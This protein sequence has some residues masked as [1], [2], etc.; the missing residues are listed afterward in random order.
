LP[1][2]IYGRYDDM[3]VIRGENVY[4]SAIEDVLRKVE[5]FGGEFQIIVSRTDHMDELLVQAEH[6]PTHSDGKSIEQLKI[7]MTEQL[8][9]RLGIR[10]TIELLPQG[11]LPRTEFKS[12]RIVD[13][14]DLYQQ[15]IGGNRRDK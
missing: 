10:P 15:V 4:P 9:N 1:E 11:L 8:R 12:R 6:A 13:N 5:G 3:L 2:G 7:V 14:R